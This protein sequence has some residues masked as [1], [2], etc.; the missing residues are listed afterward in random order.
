MIH[1]GPWSESEI[2]F[3]NER[4]IV[5]IVDSHFLEIPKLLSYID[6]FNLR[7]V[8]EVEI[9]SL[10]LTDLGLNGSLDQIIYGS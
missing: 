4:L 5:Y 10:E 2:H 6:N 9:S 7:H 3:T 8:S 1:L